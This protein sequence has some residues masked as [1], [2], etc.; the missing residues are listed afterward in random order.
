MVRH[1]DAT[2]V[3]TRRRSTT[4]RLTRFDLIVRMRLYGFKS[5]DMVRNAMKW[6]DAAGIA[7]TFI[8]Y[9]REPLAPATIDDWFARAG[10]Q[11][12]FNRNST[13]YRQLDDATKAALTPARAKALILE[14]TNF[15]KRPLLDTGSTILVGFKAATWQAEGLR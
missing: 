1:A 6:L 7:Y 3:A 4:T 15:I 14:D 11:T 12:V 5:C 9:R 8:D 2:F 13:S 10:W